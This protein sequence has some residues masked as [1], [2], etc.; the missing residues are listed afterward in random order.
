M[1]V[2]QK[3]STQMFSSPQESSHCLLSGAE[4]SVNLQ[5]SQIFQSGKVVFL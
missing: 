4:I 1:Q 5:L 2:Y 3:I